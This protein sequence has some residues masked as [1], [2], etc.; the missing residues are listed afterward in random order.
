MKIEFTLPF[1]PPSNNGL[2]LSAGN[3]RVLIPAAKQFKEEVGWLVK[4]LWRGEPSKN[5]FRA[6]LSFTFPDKRRRDVFNYEKALM[7]SMEGIVYEDDRQVKIGKVSREF[8]EEPRTKVVIY[9]LS[10]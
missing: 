5:E 7:D 6:D 8:G 1:L 10:E 3:R 9:E 2:Y 4:S